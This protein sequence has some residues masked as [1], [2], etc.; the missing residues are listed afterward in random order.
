MK[1]RFGV[2]LLCLCL[3]ACQAES[4]NGASNEAGG[5]QNLL[6]DPGFELA[7]PAWQKL[8]NG[9]RSVV[10]FPVHSGGAAAEIQLSSQFDRDIFQIVGIVPVVE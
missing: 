2:S 8:T 5:L 6:V 10:S 4:Q 1:C 3:V 7:D 9:G